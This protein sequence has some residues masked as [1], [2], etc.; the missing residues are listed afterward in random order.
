MRTEL[1]LDSAGRVSIP[2][3]VREQLH[4]APGDKIACEVEGENITLHVVRKRAGLTRKHGMWVFHGAPATNESIP[5]LI[6]RLRQDR[7]AS[8]LK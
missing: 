6:D 4:L 2:K 5:D 3:P 7:S 8:F 1:T